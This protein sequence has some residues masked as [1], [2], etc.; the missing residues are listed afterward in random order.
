MELL[1]DNYDRIRSLGKPP[2]PDSIV[3]EKRSLMRRVGGAIADKIPRKKV[4]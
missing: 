2:A 1:P 4:I 3:Q